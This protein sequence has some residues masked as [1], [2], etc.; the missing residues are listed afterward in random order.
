MKVRW[1]NR[2]VKYVCEQCGTD[3]VEP[4][5]YVKWDAKKQDWNITEVEWDDYHWCEHCEEN[6]PIREITIPNI[7]LAKYIMKDKI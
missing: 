5:G 7:G 4:R 6:M 3:D 2:R 1:H